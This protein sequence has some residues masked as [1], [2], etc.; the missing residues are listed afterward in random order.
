LIVLEDFRM[1]VRSSSC[2]PLTE[3]SITYIGKTISIFDFFGIL[4]RST[5]GDMIS[6]STVY[7]YYIHLVGVAIRS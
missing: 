4:K 3:D 5:V 2:L 6:I 1:A 7:T